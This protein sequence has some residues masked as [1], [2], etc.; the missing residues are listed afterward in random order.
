M[1]RRKSKPMPSYI[2]SEEEEKWK[3]FCT[4]NNIRIS[5]YGIKGDENHWRICIN[6]GP[7]KRGEEC[8]F[9]PH[10][11]DRN[12]IWPELYKMCKYYYDKYK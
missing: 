3:L 9:A 11:Y 5:P 6:L 7:Y 12:Q 4:R 1:P 8:N 10:I 2:P